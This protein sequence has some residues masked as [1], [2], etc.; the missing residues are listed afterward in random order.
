LA[1]KILIN[2]LLLKRKKRRKIQQ[3]FLSFPK[4]SSLSRIKNLC[5]LTGR[6]KSVYRFFKISRLQFRKL[7]SK[8]YLTGIS[9]YSW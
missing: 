8:G 4:I 6:P 7:A 9:K 3:H 5:I 1:I 2:N